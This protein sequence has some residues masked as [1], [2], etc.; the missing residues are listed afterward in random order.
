[1]AP[2]LPTHAKS[3]ARGSGQSTGEKTITFGTVNWRMVRGQESGVRQ[4]TARTAKFT[5]TSAR[6]IEQHYSKLLQDDARERLNRIAF[7]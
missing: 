5:G 7:A 4:P 6:M 3:F 1:M 2:L